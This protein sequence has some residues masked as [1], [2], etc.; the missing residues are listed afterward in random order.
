MLDCL[1]LSEFLYMNLDE[2]LEAFQSRFVWIQNL[3]REGLFFSNTKT[4]YIF[5]DT[6][7]DILYNIYICITEYGEE[8]ASMKKK[9]IYYMLVCYIEACYGKT[10]N[11]KKIFSR[12]RLDV[13]PNL[14]DTHRMI[15]ILKRKNIFVGKR[16]SSKYKVITESY[17]AEIDYHYHP[18]IGQ[19]ELDELLDQMETEL[20]EDVLKKEKEDKELIIKR[21]KENEE[22][23]E[24]EKGEQLKNKLKIEKEKMEEEIKK[25]MLEIKRL[26]GETK[27][28][29]GENKQNS[30]IEVDDKEFKFSNEL[31]NFTETPGEIITKSKGLR[32]I[33]YK[34]IKRE[35]KIKSE[36]IESSNSKIKNLK[37]KKEFK[38]IYYFFREFFIH[39]DWKYNRETIVQMYQKRPFELRRFMTSFR[40]EMKT[41]VNREKHFMDVEFVFDYYINRVMTL[42]LKKCCIC[43]E[44]SIMEDIVYSNMFNLEITNLN[45]LESKRITSLISNGFKNN[46][47]NRKNRSKR[48]KKNIV[49]LSKLFP[50]EYKIHLTNSYIK[51]MLIVK[52][53]QRKRKKKKVRRVVKNSLE[54]IPDNAQ[55]TQTVQK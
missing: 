15:S 39:E 23:Q 55:K 35:N 49:V 37:K 6:L 19:M 54:S 2:I 5:P 3:K 4:E 13:K 29:N 34:K 16:M 45:I 21:K 31:L 14:S 52:N 41:V 50:N 33:N 32:I 28:L 25:I 18:T 46:T 30:E 10:F 38:K 8:Y 7:N 51:D 44:K 17:D 47:K 48:Y 36:N 11:I 12:S 9:D 42:K 53:E 1:V 20:M 24:M 22:K 43:D 26:E 40:N 27:E